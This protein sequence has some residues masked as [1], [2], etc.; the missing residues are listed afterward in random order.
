LIIHGYYKINEGKKLL[1]LLS[2]NM[3]NARYSSN[4]ICI[5]KENYNFLS[6]YNL[7][8]SLYLFN[9]NPPFNIYT[10]KSHKYLAN[11]CRSSKNNV[12]VYINNIE[13]DNSPFISYKAAG[14][15]LKVP[16][17]NI[18]IYI[19]TDIE[20]NGYYLYSKRKSLDINT[21]I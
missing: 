6:L 18:S 8:K 10:A 16:K 3:N 9:P 1:I 13:I 20:I 17:A 12:Y 2:K 14:I 4:I 15:Y 11:L 21:Q 19:D 7:L 5:K